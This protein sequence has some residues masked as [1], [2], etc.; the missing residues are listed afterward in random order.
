MTDI[1][2]ID[3]QY[4]F[5]QKEIIS[6]DKD[7]IYTRGELYFNKSLEDS[8]YMIGKKQKS[9]YEIRVHG[10]KYKGNQIGDWYYEKVYDEGKVAIDSIINF[11]AYCDTNPINTIKKF[12]HNELDR[13]RG[14][15][16][17]VDVNDKLSEGDTLRIDLQFWHDTTRFEKRVGNTFFIF[18]PQSK[19]NYCNSNKHVIDSFPIRDNK[20]NLRMIAP[21]KGKYTLLGYYILFDKKQSLQLHDSLIKAYEVHVEMNFEVK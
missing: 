13:T 9:G 8:T 17:E 1:D 5:S 6:F 16:Y 11:I 15:F 4:K 3:Q 19:S 21:E 12:K 14:Y 7:S 18:L 10:W 20:A 2:K